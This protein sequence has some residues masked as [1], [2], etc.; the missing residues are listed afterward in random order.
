MNTKLSP[1][2][3]DIAGYVNRLG[4]QARR[5]SIEMARANTAAK[6][7]TLNYI[8]DAIVSREEDIQT[9]NAAD[10]KAAAHLESALV[11][12]LELTPNRIAAMAEGL[13]QI[14][15]LPD[16]IG[17]ISDLRYRPTGIQ[18]GRMRVPLGVVG[19]IYESRPN[20]TADAAGL[21]LKSGNATILRGG[22]E[23]LQSN[24]AISRC[25]ESGLEKAGL[26]AEAVQVVATTDRSA[27]GEL[28]H[29]AEYVDV[30]VPRGGKGLNRARDGRGS[31]ADD[32]TS[33]WRL[34]CLYRCRCR[35]R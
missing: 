17:E 7:A 16:P 27:V 28:L 24:Q 30:I 29:A 23:A 8:A 26:P 1:E 13:R 4:Q 3:F 19:I 6:N 9:A 21:C 32:Q 33:R 18:V 11:D 35:P 14:S 15:E 12:R 10:L 5:A 20:V 34:P 31:N 2:Q 22:S 25:I